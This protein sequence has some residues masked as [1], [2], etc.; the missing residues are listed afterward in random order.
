MANEEVSE[1]SRGDFEGGEVRLTE[2]HAPLCF[3]FKVMDGSD[4]GFQ[5][6][7]C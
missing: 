3:N 2:V 1:A 5:K 7:N 4:G 6:T